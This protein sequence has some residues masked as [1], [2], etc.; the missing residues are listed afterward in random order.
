MEFQTAYTDRVRPRITDWGED[1]TK[2]S[3]KD[4]VDVNNIVKKYSQTG[5]MDHVNNMQ[6]KF[7]D[8]S[9]IP[10][11]HTAM[12]QVAAAEEMFLALPAEIRKRFGNSAVTFL[13]FA[14]DPANSDDMVELG[15][16]PGVQDAVPVPD[17]QPDPE[18][19]GE[20]PAE[21]A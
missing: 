13:Q 12:N 8:V 21:P 5:I 14:Q 19:A 1:M 16:A 20:P 4:E 17:P 6:G 11:L 15:L 10:D 9:S 2:Q 7:T 3:F 18:P